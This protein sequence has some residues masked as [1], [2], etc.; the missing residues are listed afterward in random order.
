MTI[1][2]RPYSENLTDAIKDF[3]NRIKAGGL[4]YR[5]HEGPVLRWPKI[6]NRKIY[7]EYFLA[8]ENGSI[9]RGGYTLKY[10]EFVLNGRIVSVACLQNPLA[11]GVVSR[12]HNV[13]GIKLLVHAFQR[14]PLL[15]A[16][17]MGSYTESLPQ[18]LKT[19]GWTLYSIPF[20]FKVNH[21]LRFLRN[22]TYFRTTT[23][24]KALADVLAVT[25]LG[26]AGLK[27]IQGLLN[28]SGPRKNS[29]FTEAVGDF[30]AWADELWKVCQDSYSMIAVR[31]SAALNLLY[32]NNSGRFLRL[33]VLEKGE[34]IGWAV[35]LDTSM[36]NHKQFGD[37][38]VGS[39]VDC[40]ALPEHAFKVIKSATRFLEKRG[41]DL[42]VSN[43]A[44][45]AWCSAL[46]ASGFIH[47]PSN[48][49]FAVSKKITEFL[50][51]FDLHKTRIHLNRGDGDGPIHL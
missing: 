40:L 3:N 14:Q 50:H 32:P 12:A 43:Q 35:V 8:V 45:P 16:L 19:M 29:V 13:I 31:D 5:L 7:Q 41:V 44:H 18:L 27:L 37:L 1:K 28:K 10:Q 26:W 39:I 11:E 15:F 6:N 17:G 38:R 4:P 30:S 34:A 22:L 9:V 49:I 46:R 25:G 36:S 47:G 20:Y 42:I 24:R 23:L 48:F 2:I 51:P 33:K 21:P